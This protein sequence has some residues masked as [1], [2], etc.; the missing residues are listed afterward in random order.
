M[1]S[2]LID[3]ACSSTFSSPDFPKT[4]NKTLGKRKKGFNWGTEI[5]CL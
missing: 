2:G 1:D 4:C 3:A 5:C